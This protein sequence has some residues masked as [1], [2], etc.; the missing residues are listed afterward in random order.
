MFYL[1]RLSY[2]ASCTYI[3]KQNTLYVS[4]YV[5]MLCA[6]CLVGIRKMDRERAL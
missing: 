2:V 3:A 6:V 4:Q 5:W 1:V